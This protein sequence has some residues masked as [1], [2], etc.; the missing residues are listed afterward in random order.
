[1][2]PRRKHRQRGQALT[3]FVV[4]ALT[5][6][7][8][9][10]LII[11]VVAKLIS[12]KQDVEIAARYAAW[13]RTVWFQNGSR[14]DLQGFGGT[15]S[16]RS[17]AAVSR[18]IDTR[19]F[20]SDM[21]QIVSDDDPDYRLDS[22][23]RL[24]RVVGGE[25]QALPKASPSSSGPDHYAQQSS[26]EAEPGGMVGEIDSFMSLVGDI[27]RFKLN[28]NGVFT[29]TVSVPMTDLTG[30]FGI[31]SL[32]MDTLTLA[33]SNVLFAEAWE[34]G[35][36][37][38]AEWLISGLLPQQLF[39]NDAVSTLQSIAELGG[40]SKELGPDYLKFG[41]VDIDPM[42]EHRLSEYGH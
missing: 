22:F 39:D 20:S 32:P 42:P 19:I 21:Q 4:V 40:I 27:S 11:P 16:S 13:E 29:A 3:E 31:D 6:L 8:P 33:S 37:Q 30:T 38:H 15:I 34:A 7:I 25:L 10:F 17:D 12:M 14:P 35:G 36:N 23:M 9:L 28:H 26:A 18:E 24:N 2:I 1:M 5:L 41:Y